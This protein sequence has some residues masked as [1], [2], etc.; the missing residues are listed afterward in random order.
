MQER[1]MHTPKEVALRWFQELW[2]ARNPA[3]IHE[4]I[5]PECKCHLEGG[6]ETVGP[7]EF[8]AFYANMMT[9]MPD[10]QFEIRNCLE[11]ENYASIF[12]KCTATCAGSEVGI[13]GTTWIH[14]VDGKIVEGWDCWNYGGFLQSIS[15]P[16]QA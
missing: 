1:I 12:W 3:V 9:S 11:N 5:T 14:V 8:A 10:V 6:Q 13:R 16:D 4:L 2:N 7:D 15:P